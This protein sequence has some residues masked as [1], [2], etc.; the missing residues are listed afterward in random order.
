[1]EELSLN[2]QNNRSMDIN[3]IDCSL[4]VGNRIDDVFGARQEVLRWRSARLTDSRH[5][6]SLCQ[7][8][9]LILQQGKLSMGG[10]GEF[11]REARRRG[12]A[13]NLLVIVEPAEVVQARRLFDAGADQV[14]LAD[15]EAEEL[16]ARVRS[17]LRRGLPTPGD[18]LVY[19][20]IRLDLRRLEASRQ[21][22]T[23][24]L[25]GR[26]LTLLEFF[27]RNPEQVMS[28]TAIS[29]AVWNRAYSA[30]SNV[31]EVTL[32]SLRRVLEEPYDTPV[33]HTVKG[34]GYIFSQRAPESVFN[35]PTRPAECESRP[36]SLSNA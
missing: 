27:L 14:M 4:D 31:I 11:A 16:D 33:L 29:Q 15:A 19:G 7:A 5:W 18:E 10:C 32:S 20:D 3:L 1:M 25:K 8:S 12:F 21:G 23:L 6:D 30:S 2:L 36:S 35:N 17:L 26:P 22:Q 28:R 9:L 34:H 13:G 24:P